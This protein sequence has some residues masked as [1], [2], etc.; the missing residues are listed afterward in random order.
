MSAWHL[1][2]QAAGLVAWD[3][4]RLVTSEKE[5]WI[6]LPLASPAPFCSVFSPRYVSPPFLAHLGFQNQ[7]EKLVT[8]GIWSLNSHSF[9]LGGSVFD[10]WGFISECAVLKEN[11]ILLLWVIN[12]RFSLKWYP[13]QFLSDFEFT[14][15]LGND[16]HNICLCAIK[17]WHP[18]M[19][20]KPLPLP[21]MNACPSLWHTHPL[22]HHPDNF[23]NMLC[24]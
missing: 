17:S 13:T 15:L 4:L 20:A 10:G 22:S 14:V 9:Y 16:K 3:P 24:G 23:H 19:L 7:L 18:G 8:H 1:E 5:G 21:F 2:G 11:A 6:A 12:F